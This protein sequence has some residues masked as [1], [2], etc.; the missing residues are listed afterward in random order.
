MKMRNDRNYRRSRGADEAINTDKVA[1]I[2]ST[3]TVKEG[4]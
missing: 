4:E 2:T 3:T 1:P